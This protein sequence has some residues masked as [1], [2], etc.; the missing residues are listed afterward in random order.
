MLESVAKLL[1]VPLD[2]LSTCLLERM[3]A[4]KSSIYHVPY[5]TQQAVD[6]RDAL[7]M[8]LYKNL[9]DHIISRLNA[10]M[11]RLGSSASPSSSH[12]RPRSQLLC[13]SFVGMLDIFGFENF[14]H[15]S[16][17]QLCINFANEK[18]QSQ[19][20]E[21]LVASQRAEY[22]VEGINVGTLDFPD[23]SQQLSL[24]EGQVGLT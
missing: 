23:N 21:A 20:I 13:G 18:L 2:G 1:H 16:L 10:A 19:F 9:F 8:A 7:A 6:V 12:H 11:S 4:G 14:G 24:L 5:S 15:N 3:V 17:E 22:E